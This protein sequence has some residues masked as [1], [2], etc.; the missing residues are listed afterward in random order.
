MFE[1]FEI[2]ITIAIDCNLLFEIGKMGFILYY[3]LN[4]VKISKCNIQ[5]S[6]RLNDY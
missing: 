2:A 6:L 3:L 1:Y 4:R 5:E